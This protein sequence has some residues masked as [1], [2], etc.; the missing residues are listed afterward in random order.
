MSIAPVVEDPEEQLARGIHHK[1]D[2][3]YDEAVVEF[4]KVLTAHPDHSRAHLE[5][6]L[7][8]SFTG[9]FDESIAELQEA[10]RLEPA[11]LNYRVNL[12]KT[13]TMLGMYDEGR[14]QFEQI[15][16]EGPGS[17]EAEEAAKQL[18]FFDECG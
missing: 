17:E 15:I 18:R 14:E 12:G 3:E 4:L 8:Y 10:V 16:S 13:Y 2:G 7:V 1:I 11:N 9:L 6:G 5:L